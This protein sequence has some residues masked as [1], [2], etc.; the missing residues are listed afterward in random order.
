[1]TSHIEVMLTITDPADKLIWSR[2]ILDTDLS[3]YEL[4]CTFIR[5]ATD[6]DEHDDYNLAVA[7]KQDNPAYDELDPATYPFVYRT[8]PSSSFRVPRMTVFAAPAS[9]VY[10]GASSG[11]YGNMEL[12]VSLTFPTAMASFT[13]ITMHKVTRMTSDL[14]GGACSYKYLG[15]TYT[16]VKTSAY[17]RQG[18]QVV[19]TAPS[20]FAAGVATEFVIQCTG[21]KLPLDIR[22]TSYNN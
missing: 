4:R 20:T 12:T 16:T 3:I 17:N 15:S 6:F 10:T 5:A 8:V 21:I 1:M 7:V 19:V 18:L 22:G 11:G 13:I 2:P 14:V 9:V